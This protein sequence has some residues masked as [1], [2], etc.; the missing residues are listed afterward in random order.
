M[1]YHVIDNTHIKHKKEI[2]RLFSKCSRV[3]I[4]SPFISDEGV[5]LLRDCRHDK[6]ERVTVGTVVNC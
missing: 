1:G 3:L 2:K 5:E 4:A 6:F